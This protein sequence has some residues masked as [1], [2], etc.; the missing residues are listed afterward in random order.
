MRRLAAAVLSLFLPGSGHMILGRPLRGLALVAAM[1]ATTASVPFTRIAGLVAAL[2]VF[3]AIAVDTQLLRRIAPPPGGRL[4]LQLVGLVALLVTVR[5]AMHSFYLEAFRIPAG[6]M[7]PTVAVGDHLFI[8]K[9]DRGA[10]RGDVIVFRYPVHPDRDFIKR[11]VGVAGDTVEI[12]GGELFVNGRPTATGPGTTGTYQD[13]DENTGTW[14]ERAARYVPEALDGH[15]FVAAR[16]PRP[17]DRGDSRFEVPRGSV[18]VLGDNRDNSLDSRYFGPVPLANVKGRALFV[19]WSS[20][21]PDGIR[22][23]R[24]GQIIR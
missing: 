8:A 15:A 16:D 19:W 13:F 7:A 14:S 11:V 23:D 2:L 20:G 4:A 17:V 5:F 6:S 1:V 22:W 3:L 12:R 21:G 24:L 9:Y 10:A 18:F